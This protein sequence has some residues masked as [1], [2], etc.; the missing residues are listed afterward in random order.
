M[1]RPEK[2]N[3]TKGQADGTAKSRLRTEPSY[4]NNIRNWR[5][6]RKIEKISDLAD[7]IAA[8]YPDVRGLDRVG[9]TRLE[10]CTV[11]YNEDH[12]TILSKVLQVSPRDLI[13]TNPFD[14][15]DI[16]AIYAGLSDDEKTSLLAVLNKHRPIVPTP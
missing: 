6:F 12:L 10:T 14:A 5:I 4:S 11:R 13:G 9:I 3:G 7:M 2:P 16:F 1:V 15:G 8:Q